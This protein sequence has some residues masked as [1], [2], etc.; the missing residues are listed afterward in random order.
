MFNGG[1]LKSITGL[2]NRNEMLNAVTIK[3]VASVDQFGR[4]VSV[5]FITSGK[6]PKVLLYYLLS[7]L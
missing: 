5:R 7:F 1:N 3:D 6:K 2:D 4:P